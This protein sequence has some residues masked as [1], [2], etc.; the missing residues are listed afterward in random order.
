VEQAASEKAKMDI[1]RQMGTNAGGG[2]EDI[3]LWG[4]SGKDRG[5]WTANWT[6]GWRPC[7]GG[8]PENEICWF[9]AR[10]AVLTEPLAAI[11]ATATAVGGAGDGDGDEEAVGD[12]MAD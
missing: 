12:M 2:G 9:L 8:T 6:D 3:L 7:R 1:K 10:A 5:A 4:R 11:S